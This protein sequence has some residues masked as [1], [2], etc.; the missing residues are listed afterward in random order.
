M[1]DNCPPN[2]P[3]L[4]NLPFTNEW[5]KNL[6]WPITSVDTGMHE[7]TAIVTDNFKKKKIFLIIFLSLIQILKIKKLHHLQGY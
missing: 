6:S 4:Q 1:V 5:Y 3:P 2:C 7:I